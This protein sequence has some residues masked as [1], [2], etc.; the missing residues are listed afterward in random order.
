V[1]LHI[2]SIFKADEYVMLDLMQ[3][4]ATC[5]LLLACFL[6]TFVSDP[7]DRIVCFS[8][9][10]NFMTRKIQKNIFFRLQHFCMSYTLNWIGK[11]FYVRS[12]ISTAQK[13]QE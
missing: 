7:E 6:L 3:Q 9:V 4:A 2:T 1:E 13:V 5:H 8:E 10:I 12:G 11:K